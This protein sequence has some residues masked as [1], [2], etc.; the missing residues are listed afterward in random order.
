MLLGLTTLAIAAAGLQT[1]SAGDRGWATAGKVLTGVVAGSIL[2]RALEPAP[3]YVAYPAAPYYTAP[4]V[5]VTSP[6]PPPLA[7]A[8]P[9]PVVVYQQRAVMMPARVVYVQP[10]PVVY[11]QTAPLVAYR[12]GYC[13]RPHFRHRW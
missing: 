6:P 2:A 5:V 12:L 11:V 7:Y 10:A 9:G 8:S 4:T 13:Y 1:A 3:T